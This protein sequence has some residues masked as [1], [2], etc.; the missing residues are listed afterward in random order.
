MKHKITAVTLCALMALGLGACGKKKAAT[1][2]PVAV[3]NEN[4]ETVTNAA[5]EKVT[6]MVTLPAEMETVT[7]ANGEAETNSAG[8][9]VTVPAATQASAADSPAANTPAAQNDA[10]APDDAPPPDDAPVEGGP[11][12]EE[13]GVL[14]PAEPQTPVEKFNDAL[15]EAFT[16]EQK[17][18]QW[19]SAYGTEGQNGNVNTFFSMDQ[20][21]DSTD[22]AFTLAKSYYD[23]AKT[24]A[25]AA[26]LTLA[27]Y[28]FTVLNNGV[29]VG[30]YTTTDG[31]NYTGMINGESV[32]L[33]A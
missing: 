6:E 19:F 27:S 16:D 1:K 2:I 26:G 3:T 9:P 12:G 20:A 14:P 33:K 31:V 17:S 23:T 15:L 10:N 32:S 11:E 22:A 13:A 24:T 29:T 18:N 4:G 7:N 21:N 30:M 28:E 8:L 25:A 5:G